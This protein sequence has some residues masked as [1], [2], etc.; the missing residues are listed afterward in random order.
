MLRIK[1]KDVVVQQLEDGYQIA[2]ITVNGKTGTRQ[3]RL[4]NSYP[5]LKDWLTNAHPYPTNP[6]SPL[7]CGFGRKNTGKKLA[8]N[9]MHAVY[10]AYKKTHFPRLLEDPLLP[11][12]DK[13]KIRDLLRKPWNPYIRRHT[14]ATEISKALKDSVLIDQY[15]G[16]SHSGH[17]RQ[18]YQHYYNDDSFDAMLT[19]MDGLKP[20]IPSV[21]RTLLK[22]RLC[23]NCSETN[24]PESRFCSKCKFV[25]SFDAFNETVASAENTKKTLAEIQNRQAAI[26][27][28]MKRFIADEQDWD[29]RD[30]GERK[31]IDETF[32][33]M[34]DPASKFWGD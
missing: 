6:N 15:M 25:L 12:E 34:I 30:P 14:A 7:F 26:E 19:M 5:R 33:R 18:K 31:K 10:E 32:K 17:T 4:Y 13:R 8:P 2:K 20:K 28:M 24:K 27:N 3:V 29:P 16:W 1:I 23:P 22:P 9:T 21:G 11:E